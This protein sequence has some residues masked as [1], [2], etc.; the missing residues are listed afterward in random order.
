MH[1]FN[2]LNRLLSFIDRELNSLII[3]SAFSE[4]DFLGSNVY[5]SSTLNRPKIEE[6]IY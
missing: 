2:I 3:S 4:L 6:N 5:L 1:A